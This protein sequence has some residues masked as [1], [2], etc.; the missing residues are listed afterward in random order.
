METVHLDKWLD[1][2]SPSDACL[3]SIS[4][5]F[6]SKIGVMLSMP[7]WTRGNYACTKGNTFQKILLNDGHTSAL[8]YVNNMIF[9][10]NMH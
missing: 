5:T 3:H 4:A 8:F 6:H 9:R 2:L 10:Y 7:R 1:P